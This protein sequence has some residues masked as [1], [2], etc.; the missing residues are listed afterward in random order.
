MPREVRAG[1][2]VHWQALSDGA[3]PALLLHCALAYAGAY[4][5]MGAALSGKLA[6]AAPDMP[7]HG[8]SD[9]WD[10]RGDIHDA[11]T[12]IAGTFLTPGIH[13]IGHS[14][15]AT[16]ALRLAQERGTEV[17]SLTLIEPVLFAA[18][19]ASDPDAHAAHRRATAPFADAMQ[20][21]DWPRAARIFVGAWGDGRGW[22]ALPQ[23][24]RDGFVKRIPLIAET[25]RCLNADTAG[26]LSPG[27]ME[28]VTTPT[29]LLRGTRTMPVVPAIHAAFSARLP[30]VRETLIDDAGHMLPLTHPGATA[31][32]IAAH[33]T[34]VSPT[35]QTG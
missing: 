5:P 4:A 12:A 32:A 1:F 31:D 22:D 3:E 16:V 27:R 14:F 17:A 19:Q 9:D 11:M 20:A 2:G 25:D 23:R 30:R 13:L 15:G 21:C 29:L 35:R 10:G 33:V 18:A 8:R 34:A 7:S 24:Q 26:L 28:A 6:I